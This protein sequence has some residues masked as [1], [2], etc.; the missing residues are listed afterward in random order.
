M[1]RTCDNLTSINREILSI[2]C[3]SSKALSDTQIAIES[4]QQITEIQKSLIEL[5]QYGYID[6]LNRPADIAFKIASKP[7]NAIILAAG[8]GLRMIP[9]TFECPI[10]PLKYTNRPSQNQRNEQRENHC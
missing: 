7:G 10:V 6:E 8:L 9:V 2:I 3:C 5:K 4:N 1:N